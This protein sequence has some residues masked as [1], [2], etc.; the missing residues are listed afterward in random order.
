MSLVLNNWALIAFFEM[1]AAFTRK[2]VQ[3]GNKVGQGYDN[4]T[5]QKFNI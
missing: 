2:I 4:S 3:C 1:C 5:K